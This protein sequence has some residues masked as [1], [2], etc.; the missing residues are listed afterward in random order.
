M[1]NDIKEYKKQLKNNALEEVSDT[2]KYQL[3]KR[4]ELKGLIFK[5]R[6]GR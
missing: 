1:E 5:H 2:K 6:N 4:N 3:A